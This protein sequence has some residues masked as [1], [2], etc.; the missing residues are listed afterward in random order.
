MEFPF[1]INVVLPNEITIINGDYRILN[2]G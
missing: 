2:H 1:D